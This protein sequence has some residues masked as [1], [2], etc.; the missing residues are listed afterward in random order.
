MRKSIKTNCEIKLSD[1]KHIVSR[2]DALGIIEYGNDYFREISGYNEAEL[3]GRSHNIIRHPDM[4]KVVFKLMWEKINRGED[5]RAIVK[6]LAKDG[7]YYWVVTEFKPIRDPR[8]NNIVSH[9]ALRR[10]VPQRAINSI[11]PIYQKLLQIE[12]EHDMKASEKYLVDFLEKNNTTFD[13]YIEKL[14]SPK[15]IFKRL[16]H[17]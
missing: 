7:R 1:N 11:T 5:N 2:T 4:P 13:E 12:K 8:T 6:N 14:I 9:T 16:L 17:L 10:S 3:I 15:N